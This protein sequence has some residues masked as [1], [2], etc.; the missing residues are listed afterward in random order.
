MKKFTLIILVLLSAL[1]GRE[2]IWYNSPSIK[3]RVVSTGQYS[4]IYASEAKKEAVKDALNSL[5]RF[6]KIKIKGADKF[7]QTFVNNKYSLSYSSDTYSYT[8]NLLQNISFDN[9]E[10]IGNVTYVRI[11]IDKSYIDNGIDGLYNSSIVSTIFN[12]NKQEKGEKIKEIES[13]FAEVYGRGLNEKE[14]YKLSKIVDVSE[15]DLVDVIGYITSN[16]I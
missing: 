3:N 4:N 8:D 16:D 15:Q 11:S 13:T 14:L 5:A 2:P 12:I 9:E 10:R 1:H 7:S 6:L